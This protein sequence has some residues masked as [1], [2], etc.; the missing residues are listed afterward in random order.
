[1]N[2]LDYVILGIIAVAFI[3]AL[4]YCIKN[5]KK[6]CFNCD[7]YEKCPFKSKEKCHKNK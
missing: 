3:I 7:K 2:W 1:M 5:N 4:L 6:G